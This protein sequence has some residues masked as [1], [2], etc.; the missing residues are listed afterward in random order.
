MNLRPGLRLGIGAAVLLVVPAGLLLASGQPPA[1]KVFFVAVLA[2]LFL[3]WLFAQWAKKSPDRRR[4]FFMTVLFTP[5]IVLTAEAALAYLDWRESQLTSPL[6]ASIEGLRAGMLIRHEACSYRLIPSRTYDIWGG[7]VAI[8]R[9]G[10][11]S[12]Y[13]V[14]L[15]KKPGQTRVML[16]GGSSAF[17]WGLPDG[18]D[19]AGHLRTLLDAEMPEAGRYE[20][21]NAAVPYY[22]SFQEL[23]AWLHVLYAYGPDVLIVLDGR[24]DMRNAVMDGRRWRPAS[25]GGIGET[26]FAR[27][28]GSSEGRPAPPLLERAL[29][30]SALYRRV[31]AALHPPAPPTLDPPEPMAADISEVNLAFIDQFVRHRELIAADAARRGCRCILALQPVIHVGK[32]LTPREREFARMWG[33]IGPK[34][35]AVWPKL[36][37]AAV[38]TPVAGVEVVDLTKVFAAFAGEAYIDECHYSEEGSRLIAQRLADLVRPAER[39]AAGSRPENG[40]GP[41]SR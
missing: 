29:R 27:S 30:R 23:N 22:T 20:V 28:D 32:P 35:R 2:G 41:A 6:R 10:F 40:H 33:D 25:E 39:P 17:G 7:P 37:E 15:R 12:S 1:V 31:D 24:N 14:V 4:A 18:R 34:V 8:D 21:I 16:L 13:D 36:R 9:N 38:R 19:P 5:V 26:P 3:L 11:R